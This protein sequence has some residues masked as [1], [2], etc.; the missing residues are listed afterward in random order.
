MRT[1]AVRRLE[2]EI[3]LRRAI[4][5]GELRLAYQPIV[6]LRTGRTDGVEALVRWQHPTEGLV[7]PAEFISVAEQ[8]GLIVPLGEW[9]LIEACRQAHAWHAHPELAHLTMSVNLS[10]RQ[11]AQTDIVS[12]VANILDNTKM[13]PARLVLEITESELMSDTAKSVA[14][15]HDLKALGVGLSVDDFGTGYSSLSYLKK[16][17]VDILKID[18]SFIDGLGQDNEDSSIV[19]ATISL[20]RSLHLTTIA[21]GAETAHQVHL[22]SELGCDKAQGY[23]FS[24]PQFA[25]DLIPHLLKSVQ[26]LPMR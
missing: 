24:R 23:L 2:L 15:L 11:I 3:T 16:F 9:V 19:G 18:K 4:T 14:V 13:V 1:G 20:A 12:V 22:F 21:E 10:R 17:P 5:H 8:S 25:D 7:M 26:S 6:N